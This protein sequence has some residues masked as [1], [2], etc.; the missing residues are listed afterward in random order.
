MTS[1]ATPTH[2]LLV[3]MSL[4]RLWP[5]KMRFWHILHFRNIVA[6]AGHLHFYVPITLSFRFLLFLLLFGFFFSCCSSTFY[7]KQ[8]SCTVLR[9]QQTQFP[10]VFA[11]SLP[12]AASFSFPV[13]FS[14]PAPFVLAPVFSPRNPPFPPASIFRVIIH[15][16]PDG[17]NTPHHAP[18]RAVFC[19]FLGM[20][21]ASAW[22]Y[23]DECTWVVSSS[24]EIYELPICR[25]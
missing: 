6:K 3:L 11:L 1:F 15:M 25:S 13:S 12:V 21:S 5:R 24:L 19:L 23:S 14:C 2:A 7:K 17:S 22:V 20:A 8:L 16:K 9:C 18:A 10:L 4:V